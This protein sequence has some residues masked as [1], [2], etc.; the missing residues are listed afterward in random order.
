MRHPRVP[1]ETGLLTIVS[2]EKTMTTELFLTSE[3]SFVLAAVATLAPH[4]LTCALQHASAEV[5]DDKN[6]VLAVFD[7]HPGQCVR[8]LREVAT[9]LRADKE[10]ILA[11]VALDGGALRYASAELKGD[12]EVT[13]AAAAQNGYVL[14]IKALTLAKGYGLPRSIVRNLRDQIYE[15]R[16]TA[17]LEIEQIFKDMSY[18]LS[19]TYPSSGYDMAGIEAVLKCASANSTAYGGASIHPSASA[20]CSSPLLLPAAVS[21]SPPP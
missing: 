14:D 5:R 2:R 11:A 8:V 17:A 10:L 13:A 9:R 20:A 16:K 15:K 1:E 18:P 19:S 12:A 3:A 6:F 7:A 4:A 21:S